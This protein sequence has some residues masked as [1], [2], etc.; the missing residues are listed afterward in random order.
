MIVA[1]LMS[2]RLIHRCQMLK[3]IVYLKLNLYQVAFWEIPAKNSLKIHLEANMTDHDFQIK[4]GSLTD[5]LLN[6]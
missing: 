1:S 3:V 5:F 6:W 2:N 4:I